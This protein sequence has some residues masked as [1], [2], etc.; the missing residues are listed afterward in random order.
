[1]TDIRRHLHA[2]INRSCSQAL[3][4]GKK[5]IGRAMNELQSQISVEFGWFY[6]SLGAKKGWQ[7]RRQGK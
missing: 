7:T 1:M 6:R 2:A 5:D 4:D 3:A